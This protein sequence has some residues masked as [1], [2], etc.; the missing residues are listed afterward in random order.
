M[1]LSVIVLFAVLIVGGIV[2]SL[3]FIT[4]EEVIEIAKISNQYEN[5]E[6]YK[7]L[8]YEGNTV[9]LSGN[10]STKDGQKNNDS[11]VIERVRQI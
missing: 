6:K 8:L 3:G 2:I 11:L 10:R 4:T 9:L 5:L 1:R 7:S